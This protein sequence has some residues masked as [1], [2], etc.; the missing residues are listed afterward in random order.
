[1]KLKG[2][3]Y[4]KL[5]IVL[6]AVFSVTVISFTAFMN[7]WAALAEL[8]TAIIIFSI[9]AYRVTDADKR[10]KKLMETVSEKLD[11]SQAEVLHNYPFPVAVCDSRGYISWCSIA[12][13]NDIAGGELTQSTPVTLFTNNVAPSTM[14]YGQ[15]SQVQIGERFYS[16]FTNSF[17]YNGEQY[18][19]L[20][21]LNNTE[22]KITE[23]NYVNSRP[24][25]LLIELDNLDDSRS[26]FRDSERAEIK[27]RID[28]EIDSWAESHNSAVKKIGDDRYFI[29][30]EQ[31]N[32][33]NMVSEGFAILRTVREFKYKDKEIGAT[34]S[35]GASGGDNLMEC[36]KKS[37]KAIS[38][39]LGR[40]GDQVAISTIDGYEFIGGISKSAEK[41]TKVKS[42]VVAY[43]FSEHIKNSD[44]VIIMGHNYTDLD[45][46]GS[47]IGIACAVKA[48]DK[49]VQIV[50]DKSTT[51]ALPLIQKA[52]S[53]GMEG[54]FVTLAEAKN[55]I[56]KKTLLVVVDTH[57]DTFVE[58]P[59]L[60]QMI[61]MKV[62]IDHHRRS[63]TDLNDIALFHHDPVASSA[64]EM[65]CELLQYF[66]ADVNVTRSVA[67]ALFAGIM[68]DTKNFV[69]RAGVR[70]FEAAA[71]LR[72]YN[73]DT[74]TVKKLFSNSIEDNRLRNK[75]ISDSE[76][77]SMCAVSY[78][79]IDSPDIRIISA[80]AADEL[81][82]VSD[83]KASFVMFESNGA[84]NIS[85]RS[86]GEINVQI[87]M[88][89]L[90]GGGHQ[91]MAACQLKNCTVEEAKKSLFAAIDDFFKSN[92]I[93]EN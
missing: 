85:A 57:I 11:Y 48:F 64:S 69:I 26:D 12:F 56:T 53:E 73:A 10:Y 4:D 60:Y 63:V 77:Y 49:P 6:F 62:I 82:N 67:E 78:A 30:T 86:F 81:L 19:I 80:Q 20:F 29:F 9:A 68:L 66:K 23:I 79:D 40:G 25:A 31:V 59:E 14:I 13:Y 91:T 8:I 70:T 41:R 35:I 7:I 71:F 92:I 90:G 54:L 16:V 42:R 3:W 1:M 5:L 38:M 18:Y 51:L 47:A 33:K 36:E 50:T 27:S 61:D 55:T 39:A 72:E 28:A 58:F 17:E 34:L 22:L 83:I 46:I 88:E 75:V 89:S 15:N 44:N 84:I 93:K 45:A 2:F 37:R 24:Y 21:Y 65:V 52:E 43:A 32:F 76:T 74:V 87:I